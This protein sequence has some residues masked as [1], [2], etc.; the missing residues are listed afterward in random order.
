MCV[1][2]YDF[3]SAAA[4]TAGLSARFLCNSLSLWGIIYPKPPVKFVSLR[5]AR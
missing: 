4:A 3:A 2:L 1:L 5:C